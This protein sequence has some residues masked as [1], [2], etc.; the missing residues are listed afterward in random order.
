MGPMRGFFSVVQFCPDLDR[1]ECANVGV[2]LVVPQVDFLEVRLSE[3]NEGPKQRFG[4]DAYDDARLTVAKKGIEGRL[5]HEGKDWT[6]PED[7][8]Q[9]GKREGNN[10][11][12]TTPKVILVENPRPE[13]DELYQRL[14]HVE[15]QR[16]RRQPKPDLRTAFEQKLFG[17]PLIKD[18]EVEIP[19]YGKLEVPYAYQN[20]VLN[21]VRPE[22][23]P[24][25]E[26]SATAKANDLAVKG[27]L[28]YRH[29]RD[30][31]RRQK[32]IVVGG[33]D[34]S[35]PEALKHRIDFV[36]KEHDARLVREDHIDEFVEEVR[37]EAHS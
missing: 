8:Q 3:D 33:F 12:L 17:V 13:L 23:F 26:A 34:A 5:R 10:L 7:L 14:V 20:G 6:G 32:L 16:R 25:D 37:R 9:F 24:I 18:I 22:G 27:H 29:P 4:K 15:P 19:E 28:I 31:G 11:V 30:Q 35:A 2:V 36:L 21:L 1:G